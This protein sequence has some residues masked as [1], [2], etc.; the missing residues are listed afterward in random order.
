MKVV[1]GWKVNFL[2]FLHL[3]CWSPL[4]NAKNITIS[5]LADQFLNM[6]RRLLTKFYSE[7][8]DSYRKYC[9]CFIDRHI[10]IQIVIMWY[11]RFFII[12][13]TL[14]ASN[15]LAISLVF[16]DGFQRTRYQNVQRWIIQPL[17]TLIFPQENVILKLGFTYEA[18]FFFFHFK[19]LTC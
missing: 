10:Q 16:V 6:S 5:L 13:E 18:F 9:V 3:V 12:L 15:K 14:S 17:T 8:F 2:T 19:T 4:T 7:W 11:N 1:N